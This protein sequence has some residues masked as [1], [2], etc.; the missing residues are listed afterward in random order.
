MCSGGIKATHLLLVLN[1]TLLCALF[2]TSH[3]TNS[4]VQAKLEPAGC[5][6][7]PLNST[8]T[9]PGVGEAV[10]AAASCPVCADPQPCPECPA[11]AAAD[12]DA[13]KGAAPDASNICF[14]KDDYA[15]MYTAKVAR[16]DALLRGTLDAMKPVQHYPSYAELMKT[17]HHTDG[18]IY[19]NWTLPADIPSYDYGVSVEMREAGRALLHCTRNLADAALLQMSHVNEATTKFLRSLHPGTPRHLFQLAVEM[20]CMHPR[21]TATFATFA[22]SPN[23]RPHQVHGGSWQLCGRL[24]SAMGQDVAS[25]R[26]AGHRVV[27]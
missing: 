3:T 1:L 12:C 26:S 7:R 21:M 24:S 17:L 25:R 14:S 10:K 16:P 20:A 9:V 11:P 2:Y 4:I 8:S 6:V 5:T 27:H 13:I 15:V 23:C 19:D 18:S 22:V